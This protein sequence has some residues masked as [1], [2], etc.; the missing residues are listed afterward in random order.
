MNKLTFNYIYIDAAPPQETCAEN[1]QFNS[2]GTNCEPT[3]QNPD[4]KQACTLVSITSSNERNILT[5][6]TNFFKQP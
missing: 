5:I 3:C 6:L 4:P 2:C 1:E